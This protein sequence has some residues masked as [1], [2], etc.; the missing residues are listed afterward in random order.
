MSVTRY[1]VVTDIAVSHALG[2]LKARDFI[3]SK[4]EN[5][6]DASVLLVLGPTL[7]PQAKGKAIGR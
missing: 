1:L 7:V 3:G 2:N 4:T 5:S 6:R